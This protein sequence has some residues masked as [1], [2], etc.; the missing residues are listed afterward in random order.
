[1]LVNGVGGGS[2]CATITEEPEEEDEEGL[3][4]DS[5]VAEGEADGDAVICPWFE[6]P[7]PLRIGILGL[8]VSAIS[9]SSSS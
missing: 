3:D 9:S 7:A 1:M 8:I 6:G 4:E 2:G 5:V